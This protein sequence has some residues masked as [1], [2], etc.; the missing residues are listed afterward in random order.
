[1]SVAVAGFVGLWVRARA[2]KI[3]SRGPVSF[4]AVPGGI[5][6]GQKTFRVRTCEDQVD[7]KAEEHSEGHL[8]SLHTTLAD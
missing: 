8:K 4:E 2:S 1:M 3:L 7:V 6:Q 5:C